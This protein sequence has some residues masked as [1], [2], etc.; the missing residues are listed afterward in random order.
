MKFILNMI[1]L[2]ILILIGERFFDAL[3]SSVSLTEVVRMPGRVSP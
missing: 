1:L 2:V 3:F